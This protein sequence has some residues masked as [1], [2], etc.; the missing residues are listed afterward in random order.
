V[1]RSTTAA[2]LDASF[3][4]DA[5]V[6]VQ[7]KAVSARRLYTLQIPIVRAVGF[8]VLCGIAAVQDLRGDAL[9]PQPELLWLVLGNL[10]YAALAAL[11]LRLGH[12]RSG[13]VDLS[14]LLF[15][16]DLLVWLVNLHHLEQGSLFF[17]YFLLM[18][19]VDQV[20]VGF[21]RALYFSH[22]VTA[23]Y[24]G[25]S[26]WM[27]FYDPA[28]SFWLDRLGIATTMY[29][30]GLY[31]A[32]TGLVTERLR[33]RTRQAVRTARALVESLAQKANA[34]EAQAAEL[35]HARHQA[36]QASFAKSQ[37]LAVTSHE[38]RTPMNGI[39]G[40]SELLMASPLTPMQQRYVQVAHRSA[41]AMLALI[42]DVLDLSR[43]E[44]GKLTLNLTSVDLR[45]LATEAVDLVAVTSRD[46]PITLS[47]ELA[48]QLPPRVLADPPRLRQMLVNL[49][50]NAVKFT[51]RGSVRLE[52]SILEDTQ[53]ALRLRFSVIDTGI[54]I[55]DDKIDSIFGAFT[56]VDGSS[57]RRH[58]GSGLGLAI[59]KELVDL[60][61][62]QVHVESRLG[63]GSRFWIDLQF[64]KVAEPATNPEPAPP[65]MA[66]CRYRSSSP[67]TTSS[68]RWWS[69]KC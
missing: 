5:A 15:H 36:E 60:M 37:F 19:V 42:D 33:N 62:G 30:L 64:E 58:G 13:R 56:Q 10:S 59:V 45:A 2:D 53:S 14:L 65:T 8:A 61:G 67:K 31:L 24:L 6:L 43:I 38:L 32:V 7:R 16:L 49:L 21:R 41:T 47:C 18:R 50:H 3:T 29:L 23:A 12:G 28:Q 22:L 40:A 20:G 55:A 1:N 68:T 4:L 11:L 54:G 27:S 57:T 35:E 63:A 52:V 39:L 69:K 46:K 26:V 34:L 25:Y 66:T 44:A 9:F 51:D 48:P 17:A